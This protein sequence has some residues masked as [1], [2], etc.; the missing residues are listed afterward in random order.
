MKN[1]HRH[2]LVFLESIYSFFS[3]A[4]EFNNFKT[5]FVIWMKKNWLEKN[6]EVLNDT[7][8]FNKMNRQKELLGLTT[9]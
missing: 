5:E 8:Y 7:L 9:A 1:A 3:T 4:F 6:T 2:H